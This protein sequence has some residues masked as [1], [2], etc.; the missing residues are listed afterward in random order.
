MTSPPTTT[1]GLTGCLRRGAAVFADWFWAN[2]AVGAFGVWLLGTVFRDRYTPT[3]FCFLVP[4]LLVLAVLVAAAPL[5][6]LC[7]CRRIATATAL[8]ALGPIYSMAFVENHWIRPAPTGDPAHALRLVHWNVGELQGDWKRI[9]KH[10][11]PQKPDA[12]VLS[13]MYSDAGA[14]QMAAALGPD[15][16][17][18]HV[19][20]LLVIARGPVRLIRPNDAISSHAYLVEWASPAGP[21]HLLL[22]DLPSRPIY[23]RAT[24]LLRVRDR[25][26]LLWP[27]FV[28]GD[29]NAS[30][31]TWHMS[32]MPKGYSHAYYRAGVGWSYSWPEQYPIWDIDQCVLGPRVRPIRYD[33]VATGAGDHRMQVLS[34]SLAPTAR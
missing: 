13:E 5:A 1:T 7:G 23:S 8:L 20:Q 9:L 21:I 29:F 32:H 10:I 4:T 16:R 6:W 3:A 28:V 19:R 11:G 24:W 31:R 15:F 26:E 14:K 12:V 27:D 18:F 30:R 34:F 2:V 22:V 17:A 33:L 25:I